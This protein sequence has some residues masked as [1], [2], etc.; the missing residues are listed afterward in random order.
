MR[1]EWDRG[2]PSES[3]FLLTWQN[4][5][6]EI[7]KLILKVM[8]IGLPFSMNVYQSF[9]FN[10]GRYVMENWGVLGGAI[11]NSR[12]PTNMGCGL[13]LLF[14]LEEM[15]RATIRFPSKKELVNYAYSV[16]Y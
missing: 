9:A 4:L 10:A 15:S 12:R 14:P 3:K 5:F 16:K 11:S 7:G 2:S 13:G 1:E 8:L 6:N